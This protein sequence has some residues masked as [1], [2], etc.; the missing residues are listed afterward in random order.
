[1]RPGQTS[2][3][4]TCVANRYAE[5]RRKPHTVVQKSMREATPRHLAPWDLGARHTDLRTVCQKCSQ[6]KVPDAQ[7]AYR[8]SEMCTDL[9]VPFLGN[10]P[11]AEFQT[12]N[13]CREPLCRN[14]KR[15][16]MC[17][18]PLCRNATQNVYR[19]AEMHAPRHLDMYFLTNGMHFRAHFGR[20]VHR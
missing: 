6:D 3:R 19:R 17:R 14:A 16:N 12:H 8:S 18:E 2:R 10:A 1:M 7:Y 4:T 13:M 11:R 5:I 20:T 15:H 9:C